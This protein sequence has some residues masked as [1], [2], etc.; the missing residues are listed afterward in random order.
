MAPPLLMTL[1][2]VSGPRDLHQGL[3]C[4]SLFLPQ[5][6]L[7]P[8]PLLPASGHS[9]LLSCSTHSSRLPR[10]HLQGLLCSTPLFTLSDPRVGSGSPST[11]LLCRPLPVSSSL[12]ST[13]LRLWHRACP[14]VG[15]SNTHRTSGEWSSRPHTWLFHSQPKIFTASTWGINVPRQSWQGVGLPGRGDM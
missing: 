10:S 8:Q 11:A 2:G 7:S 4:C 5:R 13:I 3:P 12:D 6:H 14:S 1:P 9:H 15:A